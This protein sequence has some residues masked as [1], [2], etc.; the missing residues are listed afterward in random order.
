VTPELLE[1]TPR[2]GLHDLRDSTVLIAIGA[3]ILVFLINTW[4]WRAQERNQ[5]QV[6]DTL[7]ELRQVDV[8]LSTM[9]DAE[10]GQRG[11]LLTGSESYLDPYTQ[12]VNT[13]EGQ[14]QA[15][16]E[17]TQSQIDLKND[18]TRLRQA[19]EA[20]MAELSSTIEAKRAGQDEEALDRIRTRTGKIEM[21]RIRD[22]SGQMDALIN[23]RLNHD[24][25]ESRSNS[26]R[27][28]ILSAGASL[29]LFAL[30]AL[31]N[32]RYRRQ[33]EAAE[34]ASRAKSTFVASMSHEFRTPLN[35][36][37]GYSEML[38]E[39]AKES[40]AAQ[41]VPDLEKIRTAGK[42]L[43]ELIN[44]VLDIS[45]IEAGKME[46]FAETFRV[47]R[48]VREV[49]DVA[50]PLAARNN[51][52]LEAVVTPD[53]GEVR[54]DQ[55]KVR[56]SLYNLVSNA[57]KFTSDGEV[58]IEVSRA[59][60]GFVIFAVRDTGVGMTPAQMGRL[61]Q[62]FAQGDASTSRRFG[63]TG[64]G[65]ALSRGFARMMGGDISVESEAG[66]GSVFTMRIPA[67]VAPPIAREEPRRDG[68][69]SG[70]VLAID[71]DPDIH[72]MLRRTLGRHGFIVET[73]RTGPDGLRLAKQLRPQA[74][75]LDVM[76][77]GMDGWT[78]LGRLKNDPATADIPVVMLTI[79]DNRNLGFAMG[80]AEYLTKPIDRERLAQVLLRYRTGEEN[81]ALVVEDE[82]DSRDVM[83]R[84]LESQGWRVR[85]ARNGREALTELSRGL[86]SVLLLDLMMPEMDG[87]ELLDEIEKKSEWRDLPVLVVTARELSSDDRARLNGHVDRVLRKGACGK[88]ELVDQ[89]GRIVAARVRSQSDV[90]G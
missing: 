26:T 31:A 11:Y 58:R 59:S 1:P 45:K 73:A 22:I 90:S 4:T 71:D 54:A 51:N 23:A 60:D 46:L 84:M 40:G 9:K 82:P 29:A 52:R 44:S 49:A 33:K 16:R 88:S 10:T 75:T 42:H 13:I 80:A 57:C 27:L 69:S 19:V 28:Q 2:P 63:G 8:I 25:R 67:N 78:V 86:P 56:Q 87:F 65:L 85:E 5:A 37:I 47:E 50:V 32:V 30:V 61:F 77:P 34:A 6:V 76:M 72:E 81:E 21:D 79:V 66:K 74:I 38:T 15:L 7:R 3:V 39:E 43:L 35:A 55:T 41:I 53:V 68:A 14:L 64:L 20:K 17:T 12:A 24:A 48:L 70:F 36:I 62:S 89:V 18:Y 83:R